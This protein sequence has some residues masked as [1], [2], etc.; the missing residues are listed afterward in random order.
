MTLSRRRNLPN[1]TGDDLVRL[2]RG[3]ELH[4]IEAQFLEPWRACPMWVGI[5]WTSE[6]GAAFR[7]EQLALDAEE[8]VAWVS[9]ISKGKIDHGFDA[10]LRIESTWERGGVRHYVGVHRLKRFTGF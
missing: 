7:A 10:E 8:A 4:L 2:P 1:F 9:S 6:A 5:Q 3:G